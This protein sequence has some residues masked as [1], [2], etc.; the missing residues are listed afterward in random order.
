MLGLGCLVVPY[1]LHA[2]RAAATSLFVTGA[3][4]ITFSMLAMADVARTLRLLLMLT[5]VWLLIFAPWTLE[6]A[7]ALLRLVEM[8]M[9]GALMVLCY[10]RGAIRQSYAGWEHLLH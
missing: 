4:T 2:S 9:G 6:G 7:S 10:P 3:F 8:L 1:I 5:G